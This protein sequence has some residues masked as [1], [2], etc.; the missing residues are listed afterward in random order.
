MQVYKTQNE[1]VYKSLWELRAWHGHQEA[2]R[3]PKQERELSPTEAVAREWWEPH[4]YTGRESDTQPC[5]GYGA[6]A[7]DDSTMVTKTDEA[8]SVSR[9]AA[10]TR[11]AGGCSSQGAFNRE[12]IAGVHLTP[13]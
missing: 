5:G 4:V 10:V 3:L 9:Q 6:T 13:L 8:A 11:E 2:P 1:Q 12:A 7:D